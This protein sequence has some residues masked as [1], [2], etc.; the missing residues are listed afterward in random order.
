MNGKIF[1]KL[2]LSFVLAFTMIFASFAPGFGSVQAARAATEPL[3]TESDSGGEETSYVFDTYNK[4]AYRM[5]EIFTR[6]PDSFEAWILLDQGSVGGTIM[7]N[8]LNKWFG[9]SG[10]VCW[11]I[12]ELGRLKVFWNNGALEYTVKGLFLND[13]EWHHVAVVRDAERELFLFYVDG[14]EV[15]RVETRQY[16]AISVMP[17][18]VGV[19]HKNWTSR[20]TPFE[21]KIREITIYNGAI[22]AERVYKDY[23]EGVGDTLDGQLMGDWVF[24]ETWSEPRVE[25]TFGVGCD[26]SIVTYEK[27]VSV[28]PTGDYDYTIAV[29]PDIQ[30]M[31]GQNRD[32]LDGLTDWLVEN[33][34]SHKIA[35]AAEVG[36]LSDNGAKEEYYQYAAEQMSKLD[37][38]I[39]YSFIQGNHDYDDN[40]STGRYSTYYNKYFSYDKYSQFSYFG[41][42]YE[43]GSME[44]WYTLFE[45]AGVKY[46]M[47]NLEFGPRTDVIRW[48]GRIC[49]MYPTRRVI[50]NT[51][52]YVSPSGDINDS[53]GRYSPDEYGWANYT[54]VT[55]CEQLYEGLIKRYANIF[56]TFNGHYISDD[57]VMRQDVGIHGNTITSIRVDPQCSRFETEYGLDPIMLMQFNESEKTID[58]IFYSPAHDKCFNIQ[59]QF[60]ISFA[61]A[62]G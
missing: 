18:Q 37:G 38:V 49:E 15:D 58:I 61:D 51:H 25:E 45:A 5:D 41:G 10:S 39:P 26:A 4:Y 59:N 24:G 52:A 13:A 14:A 44:N 47:I 8:W 55:N 60:T 53:S 62:E 35:Y 32:N 12:D 29:I 54:E 57:I 43:E 36:D 31:V 50:I 6:S 30:T 17:M 9:F 23:S 22:S 16:D 2:A 28:M 1:K 42:A 46:C 27:Y 34:A 56:L 20:K 21:G 11:E 33:A 48:A 19:D 7:G 40:C 3:N